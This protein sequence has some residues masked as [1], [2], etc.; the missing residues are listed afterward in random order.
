MVFS[1]ERA[2]TATVATATAG[3]GKRLLVSAAGYTRVTLV[4]SDRRVDVVFPD[5][6]PI[7]RLLPEAL[8]LTEGSS[9]NSVT[10]RRLALLDGQLLEP[11][12]TL[13]EVAIPDGSV[14]RIVQLAE[15]P[16]PPVVLDVTETVADDLDYRAWR[17]G[18]DAR[19]WT[20][21]TMAIAAAVAAGSLVFGNVDDG[22]RPLLVLICL[23]LLVTGAVAGRFISSAVGTTLVLCGTALGG[24]TV[25]HVATDLPARLGWMGVVIAVT[26]LAL[27]IG[28][29]LGPGG[30]IGGVTSFVMIGAWAV[31]RGPLNDT[32]AAACLAVLSTVLLGVL[33][34]IALVVSG[35]TKLDDRRSRDDTVVRTDV[36]TSLQ[37]AHRGLAL[38]TVAVAGSALIAGTVLALADDPW[39]T[40]LA[41][42][43][44]TVFA[45]RVRSF[46]LVPEVVALITAVS[47]IAYALLL[48]W[49]VAS[50]GARP[51]VVA[52][53]LAV[54][55][56]CVLLPVI[57]P[58]SHARARL[59]VL[60]DR[61]EVAAV[62]AMVPVLVGVFEVY[63]RLLESF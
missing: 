47:G 19:R 13:G 23:M 35:L 16:P 58:S 32:R 46:P 24:Y 26:L 48:A 61:L 36:D 52:V 27:G 5:D 14:V 57:N 63:P 20:A 40:A 30:V 51:V 55:A 1:S 50:E 54:T 34:R 3:D 15:A 22:G 56:G 8:K 21:T 17:W 6:E 44:G 11:D 53:L 39:A 18:A 25:T 9:T 60:T 49:L 33:P 4:G 7:G 28:T 38:G 2:R 42:L 10:E 29:A 45:I 41:V 62:V 31:A 12:R 59:R 37:I 43:L